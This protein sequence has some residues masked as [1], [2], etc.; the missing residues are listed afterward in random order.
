M[1]NWIKV[2]E[3]P[4]QVRAEI[5][6][7]VLEEH[8]IQAVVLNKKETVYQIFGQHEVLVQKDDVIAANNLIQNEITF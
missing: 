7:G 5:V 6:K 2:F 4:M 8:Q 3:S 1:E